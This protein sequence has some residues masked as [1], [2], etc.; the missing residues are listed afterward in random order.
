ML[1][2]TAS[3]N[4]YLNGKGGAQPLTSPSS[5]ASLRLNPYLSGKGGAKPEYLAKTLDDELS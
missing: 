4:P 3:L 2:T 1:L 5:T